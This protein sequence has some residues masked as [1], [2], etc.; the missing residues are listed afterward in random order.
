MPSP[1]QNLEA[2][3]TKHKSMR[4]EKELHGRHCCASRN[5]QLVSDLS[6]HDADAA[7]Y[8]EQGDRQVSWGSCFFV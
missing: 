8:M 2:G 6:E 3:A 4:M 1:L 5:G 7:G